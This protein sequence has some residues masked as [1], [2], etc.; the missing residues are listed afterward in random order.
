MLIKYMTETG[1]IY[2]SFDQLAKKISY[3]DGLVL[4]FRYNTEYDLEVFQD[5]L[6]VNGKGTR[7]NVYNEIV[8]DIVVFL[9][10]QCR[11]NRTSI[12][13]EIDKEIQDLEEMVRRLNVVKSTY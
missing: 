6:D 10:E 12:I 2:I 4:F 8:E 3:Y 5:R 1:K 7:T 13:K 9:E 11:K